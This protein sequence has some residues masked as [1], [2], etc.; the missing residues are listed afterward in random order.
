M[1]AVKGMVASMYGRFD[2]LVD[3]SEATFKT[4]TYEPTNARYSLDEDLDFLDE[5][6]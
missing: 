1:Q 4:V 2:E 3:T 6:N 5:D